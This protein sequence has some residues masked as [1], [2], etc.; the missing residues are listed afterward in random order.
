VTEDMEKMFGR[1]PSGQKKSPSSGRQVVSMA[2]K[3]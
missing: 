3:Q 1:K 2:D